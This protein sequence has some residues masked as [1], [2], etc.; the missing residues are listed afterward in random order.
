MKRIENRDCHDLYG[1]SQ[2]RF[3]CAFPVFLEGELEHIQLQQLNGFAE[4]KASM[5]MKDASS[6]LSSK[7]WRAL[8]T[9][10]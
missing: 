6:D 2:S 7:D 3:F 5:H 4:R 10:P 9:D 8:N 1:S